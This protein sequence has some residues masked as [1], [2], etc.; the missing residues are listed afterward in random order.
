MVAWQIFALF[1]L[2]II[3]M[4]ARWAPLRRLFRLLG[5]EI[6]ISSIDWAQLSRFLPEDG[7][8]IQSPKR[9]K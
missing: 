2:F 6:G 7:D 1:M 5:R 4:V 8:G 3:K 9:F